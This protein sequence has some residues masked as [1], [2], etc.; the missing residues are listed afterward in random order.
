MDHICKVLF[1]Q[2]KLGKTVGEHFLQVIFISQYILKQSTYSTDILFILLAMQHML[3]KTMEQRLVTVFGMFLGISICG[4]IISLSQFRPPS[5]SI[6]SPTANALIIL[7]VSSSPCLSTFLL[8][9]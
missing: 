3:V 1:R 7:R 5:I 4:F 2:A 9:H 8:Q 6:A